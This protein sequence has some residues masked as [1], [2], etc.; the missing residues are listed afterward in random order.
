MSRNSIGKNLILTSFGESHGPFIGSILDGFPAGIT[1]DIKAINQD[2]ARRRPGQSNLTTS[3]NETDEFQIISG[4]FE[5][6][7]T[8]APITFLIANKDTKP[9]DYDGLKDSYRPGHADFLYQTKYGIR[10]HRGGGRSSARITAGWVAAGSLA[11]QYLINTNLSKLSKP[12]VI[13]AWVNQIYTAV[14]P[15]VETLPTVEMI[16]QSP[17]RCPNQEMS[18]KMIQLIEAA[19]RDGD[20]LGGMIRLTIEN[21]PIGLGEPLFGKLKAVL[22]QYLLSINAIKGISFGEGFNAANLKGSDN[23]DSWMIKGNEI[24][25]KTNHSGGIIGGMAT[26]EPIVVD[27]VFKPTSTIAKPQQTIN[28]AMEETTL[29][30]TGRHDPCVLPRAVPI[31][32]AMANLAIMDLLLEM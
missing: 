28:S 23:N 30:A 15:E 29:E 1:I 31:V 21:S 32:E 16:E 26:G 19:K 10:D 5:G 9:S 22:G 3:R 17:V 18:L 8:G 11:K 12:I 7:S 25:T 13:T 6:Q 14:C 24:G 27:L 4:V 20:S 2:M